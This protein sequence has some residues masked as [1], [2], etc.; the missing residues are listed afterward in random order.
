LGWEAV[1]PP[2]KKVN[3]AL[4]ARLIANRELMVKTLT[5]NFSAN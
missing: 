5:G 2:S 1:V 4:S 3:W